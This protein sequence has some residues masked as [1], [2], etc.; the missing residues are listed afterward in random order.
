MGGGGS[1]SAVKSL[2][3]SKETLLQKTLLNYDQLLGGKVGAT[4]NDVQLRLTCETTLISPN[5]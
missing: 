2:L 4:Y 5:M 3:V 1:R